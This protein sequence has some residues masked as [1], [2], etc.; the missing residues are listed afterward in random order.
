MAVLIFV[1]VRILRRLRSEPA[2]KASLAAVPIPDLND[3]GIK[4]DDLPADRW[5][6]LAKELTEKG[7]LRPAMR[8][9][10]LATLAQLGEHDMITIEMYKS[11]RDYENELK[12]RAHESKELRLLFAKSLNVFERVW[13]GMYSIAGSDFEQFA[14]NQQRIMAIAAN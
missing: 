3:E 2:E 5:L 14:A 9:L 12:R 8:A 4:A 10:Y 1:L 7:E 13:Y 6:L 11:N